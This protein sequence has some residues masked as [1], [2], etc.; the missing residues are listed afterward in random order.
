MGA[1]ATGS[2]AALFDCSGR[3]R[4]ECCFRS[5]GTDAGGRTIARL[6]VTPAESAPIVKFNEFAEPLGIRSFA[7]CTPI[8]SRERKVLGTFAYY[9]F[10][11]RDPSPRDARLVELMK[12]AAAV[13]IERNRAKAALRRL[14]ETLEQRE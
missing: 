7:W 10:E 14:N 1:T 2:F 3:G 11:A 12:R 9:Y 5:L 8:F 4:S 6:A 13:A